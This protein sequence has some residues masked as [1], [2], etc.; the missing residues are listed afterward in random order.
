[1]LN[2]IEQENFLNAR[3]CIDRDV[4][5]VANAGSGKTKLL[6]DHYLTL[7]EKGWQP[8]QIAAFTFTEKAAN[9]LKLRI[10]KAQQAFQYP[11]SQNPSNSQDQKNFNT[12]SLEEIKIGTFHQFCF[13]LLQQ[14]DSSKG[15][16]LIEEASELQLIESI[17]LGQ[18]NSWLQSQN[19][20]CLELLKH[21]G[22]N[23][24]KNLLY[25][26]VMRRHAMPVEIKLPETEEVEIR[27]LQNLN[28]LTTSIEAALKN[29]K[30]AR[31]WLSF[32]DLEILALQAITKASSKQ[33][34]FLSSLNHL[35]VDEF[36]DSSP[37][38]L[39]ILDALKKQVFQWGK[40]IQLY[41]VGDA[42]QSIYRFRQVDQKLIEASQKKIVEAGGQPFHFTQNF[43][44]TAQILEFVNAYASQAFPDALPSSPCLVEDPHSCVQMIQLNLE[45]KKIKSEEERKQQADWV[46]QQMIKSHEQGI[47]YEDMAVLYRSSASAKPY[48]ERLK[49]AGIPF[50]I[51]GGTNL[52]EKQEIYDLKNLILFLLHP[53]EEDLALLGV[54]RSPLFALSDLCLFLLGDF[55]HSVSLWQRLQSPIFYQSVQEFFSDEV[56]KLDWILSTLKDWQKAI[57]YKSISEFL[58]SIFWN[59]RLANLFSEAYEDPEAEWTLPQFIDWVQK[60]ELENLPMSALK[61]KALFDA[62]EKR[63]VQKT[64]LSHLCQEGMGVSLLTIHAAKGLEFKNVYLVD[65]ARQTYPDY[66]IMQNVGQEQALK[67]LDELDQFYPTPRYAAMQ[68]FHK[69][70]DYEESKRL[71]YV[72]LTR[73][74]NQ[75]FILLSQ[76]NRVGSLQDILLKNLEG[77]KERWLT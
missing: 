40:R 56:K 11:A 42:K 52:F 70:E 18:L 44:S 3:D 65:L 48:L 7:L 5:V 29:K 60:I 62:V 21:F 77:Q 58:E 57:A 39:A 67:L 28:Q 49:A 32:D 24:L 2:K 19:E 37:R 16:Q 25:E 9:E 12:S 69:K 36:Q 45:D 31:Q 68:E 50:V 4:I 59:Y 73:A 6:V 34:K 54:L 23:R 22:A 20:A 33:K 46:L 61:W 72:A 26:K 43:R 66:P 27:L 41:C 55:P 47:A 51:K 74:K 14:E 17:L 35:L 38:Q 71:L 75:L 76:K 30:Q 1:M 13:S 8:H 63:K 15:M 53:A 64:P 10:L